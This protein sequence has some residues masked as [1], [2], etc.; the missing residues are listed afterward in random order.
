MGAASLHGFRENDAA[1]LH[2]VV[3]SSCPSSPQLFAW[4]AA[5]EVSWICFLFVFFN[6]LALMACAIVHR[7]IPFSLAL[8]SFASAAG[9]LVY[10]P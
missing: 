1:F 8:T 7:F 2:G 4:L 3:V 5:F 6:L 9:A 10:R